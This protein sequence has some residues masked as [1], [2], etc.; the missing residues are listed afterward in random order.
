FIQAQVI[1]FVASSLGANLPQAGWQP[2]VLAA[3][4][5]LVSA[6][7]FTLCP[8]LRLISMPPLRELNRELTGTDKLR[9]LH[10]LASAGTIYALL[11]FYR[12][13]WM[14]SAAVFIR[15][16]VAAV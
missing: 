2:Y 3:A 13:Q 6:V 10:W 11:L 16:G 4:T 5:G 7:M 15:G 9:W 1:E 14:L 12:Q 8:L